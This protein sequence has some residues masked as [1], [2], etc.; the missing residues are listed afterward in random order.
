M[1]GILP[2]AIRTR[3]EKRGFNDIYWRGLSKNLPHLERMVRA[4]VLS[5]L[6]IVDTEVLIRAMRQAAFG[7][8]DLAGCRIDK[9][10]ALAAWFAEVDRPRQKGSQP[11]C[12]TSEEVTETG[13]DTPMTTDRGLP[14][15]RRLN[16][17]LA[18]LALPT[19]ISG[20]ED[21]V[22]FVEQNGKRTGRTGRR[23]FAAIMNNSP[24][25]LSVPTAAVSPAAPQMEC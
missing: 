23:P 8:G 10:L 4:S 25:W 17:V 6:G 22:T 14:R 5:D 21:A 13:S 15:N 16:L 19:V 3:R 20:T 9:T 24:A 1:Q 7:L 2:E 12:T 11:R 18:I